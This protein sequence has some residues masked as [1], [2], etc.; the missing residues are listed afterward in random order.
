M[1]R[2]VMRGHYVHNAVRVPTFQRKELERNNVEN[3]NA[4]YRL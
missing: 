2:V 4:A 3:N 1:W